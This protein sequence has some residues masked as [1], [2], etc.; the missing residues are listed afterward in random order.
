MFGKRH[1]NKKP[2]PDFN[3]PHSELDDSFIIGEEPANP[4]EYDAMLEDD[5]PELECDCD[6]WDY[7]EIEFD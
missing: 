1:R 2:L 6:E 5:Q 3:R 7:E 4:F